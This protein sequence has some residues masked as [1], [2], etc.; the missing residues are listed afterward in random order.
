MPKLLATYKYRH[1]WSEAE[2]LEKTGL[3]SNQLAFLTNKYDEALPDCDSHGAE[4]LAEYEELAATAFE[5]IWRVRAVR[6]MAKG[7]KEKISNSQT[8]KAIQIELCKLVVHN[9]TSRTVSKKRPFRGPELTLRATSISLAGPSR[10]G[11]PNM[12]IKTFSMHS[13][14][15]QFRIDSS[16]CC[17]LSTSLNCLVRRRKA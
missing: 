11:R 14:E 1:R 10:L 15:H 12:A 8:M 13:Q 9:R 4:R 7:L 6:S 3:T 2:W 5:S 17:N 16:L